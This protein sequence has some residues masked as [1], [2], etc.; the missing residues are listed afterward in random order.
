MNYAILT[1]ND[2]NFTDTDNLILDK[3]SNDNI[4]LYLEDYLEF[5]SGN[6]A[7]NLNTIFKLPDNVNLFTT[8]IFENKDTIYQMV[9]MSLYDENSP[10]IIELNK[11]IKLLKKNNIAS[12]FAD[13]EYKIYGNVVIL[14]FNINEITNDVTPQS[15]TF[16]DM[17]NVFRNKKIFKGILIK[18]NNTIDTVEYVG[19]PLT[20][21]K[22]AYRY[23]EKEMLGYVFMFFIEVNPTNNTFNTLATKLYNNTL[24]TS[25]YGNVFISVRHKCNDIRYDIPKFINIDETYINKIV[26]F[27]SY[28]YEPV[29]FKNNNNKHDNIYLLIERIYNK[30]QKE[31]IKIKVSELKD[32]LLLNLNKNTEKEL[33]KK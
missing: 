9:H 7:D 31:G 17:I 5:K 11:K 15:I 27:E 26:L 33:E 22:Y 30:I 29:D 13:N 32:K 21:L 25:I 6:F 2:L 3:F 18:P 10:E 24:D 23:Y 8:N 4:E 16:N 12:L 20:Y 19:N 1:P 28:D 14:K